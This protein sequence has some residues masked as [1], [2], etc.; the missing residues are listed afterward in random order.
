MPARVSRARWE[1]AEITQTDPE[2]RPAQPPTGMQRDDSAGEA[3][4]RH[5]AEARAADHLGEFLGLGKLTDRFDEIAIGLGIASH[6]AADLRNHVERIEIVEPVEARHVDRR[7]LQAEEMPAELQ[8]AMDLTKRRFD[9]RHVADAER[10]GDGVEA[11]VQ[12]RQRLGI[13]FDEL[14]IAMGLF[15]A[16]AADRKHLGVDVAYRDADTLATAVGDAE[17]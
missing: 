9:P 15:S 7:K 2:P 4:E 13:G 16:L 8:H 10:D 14:D 5:A 6:R 1:I 11:L 12:K 17:R 3:L